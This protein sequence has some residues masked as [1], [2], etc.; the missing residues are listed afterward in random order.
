LKAKELALISFPL[1][2]KIADLQ[3]DVRETKRGLKDALLD[4]E[5]FENKYM[6]VLESLEMMALDKE[7]AEERV[8]SLKLEVMLLTDKIEE[9]SI[10]LDVVK[11][12]T[13][14]IHAKNRYFR[15]DAVY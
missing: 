3:K 12:G 6:D 13:G 4:K 11:K 7:M 14:K 5:A 8:E 2:D 9:I 1:L 10:D 15:L